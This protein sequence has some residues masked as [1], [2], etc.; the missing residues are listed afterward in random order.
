M[1]NSFTLATPI[2]AMYIVVI[3]GSRRELSYIKSVL[4]STVT[5]SST[6]LNNTLSAGS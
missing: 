4:L 3:L 6:V 2:V 5:V 1:V